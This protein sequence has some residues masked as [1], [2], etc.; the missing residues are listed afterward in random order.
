MMNAFKEQFSRGMEK[1]L[2]IGSDIPSLDG[3]LIE[4]YFKQLDTH[5]VVIGPAA[6]G[7]YYLIGMRR[8][9]FVPSLFTRMVWSTATVYSVTVERLRNRKMSWYAGPVLQDIDTLDDLVQV[10]NDPDAAEKI[11][12]LCRAASPYITVDRSGSSH[13]H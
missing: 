4:R 13:T 12:A 3:S 5:D 11:A 9:S 6:D 2:L 10:I 1:V 7:G 8:D